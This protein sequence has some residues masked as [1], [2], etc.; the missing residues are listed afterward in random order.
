MNDMGA[1]QA[2]EKASAQ[3]TA[4]IL[5][6]V[7]KLATG[8]PGIKLKV[9]SQSA[10]SHTMLMEHDWYGLRSGNDKAFRIVTQVIV[11]TTIVV[12]RGEGSE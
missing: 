3:V 9:E 11:V 5:G 1:K 10:T 8:S 4:E 12:P 6:V 7:A 2:S